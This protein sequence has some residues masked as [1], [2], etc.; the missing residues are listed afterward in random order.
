LLQGII[1]QLFNRFGQKYS[2]ACHVLAMAP[3]ASG[4]P[5]LP[6]F[7]E[8]FIHGAESVHRGA[9]EKLRGML[10]IMDVAVDARAAERI[11]RE[12]LW[13]LPVL[14]PS[15]NCGPTSIDTPGPLARTR[16]WIVYLPIDFISHPSRITAFTFREA[17]AVVRCQR[18]TMLLVLARHGL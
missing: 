3:V 8:S 13:L 5:G 1:N 2:L 4:Q 6:T 12:D 15:W 16:G 7:S 17:T 11:L 18:A 10:A 14:R 9:A